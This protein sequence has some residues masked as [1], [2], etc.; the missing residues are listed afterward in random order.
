MSSGTL[1]TYDLLLTG[2]KAKQT[3]IYS[4]FLCERKQKKRMEFCDEKIV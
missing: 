2:I 4:P 3:L 1:L